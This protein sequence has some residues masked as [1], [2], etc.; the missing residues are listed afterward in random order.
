MSRSKWKGLFLCH[1][2]YK[3][4]LYLKKKVNI[5]TF[6]QVYNR[7]STVLAEF[8]GTHCKVY[9]GLKFLNVLVTEDKVGHKFG[10]F[11]YT[12]KLR[13]C[14]HINNDKRRKNKGGQKKK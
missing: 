4:Y 12:R 5:N 8:I 7:S 10:E 11:A 13:K 9:N 3:K 1:S 2:L 6:I 14:I